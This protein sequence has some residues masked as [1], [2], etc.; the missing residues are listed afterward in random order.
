M[1]KVHELEL[2]NCVKR[3]E[4]ASSIPPFYYTSERAASDE[5][6]MVFQRSWTGVRRTDIVRAPGDFITLEI[7]GQSIILLRDTIGQLRA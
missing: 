5:V 6:E 2:V 1:N 4:S 7:A 3:V